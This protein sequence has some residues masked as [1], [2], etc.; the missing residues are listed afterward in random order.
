MSIYHLQEIDLY[1]NEDLIYCNDNKSFLYNKSIFPYIITDSF[2][3][4]E[5]SVSDTLFKSLLY[6]YKNLLKNNL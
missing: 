1:S 2:R 5:Q 4:Q 3:I 6:K